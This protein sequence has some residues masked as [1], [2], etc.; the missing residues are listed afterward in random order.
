[1]ESKRFG[2]R[3]RELRAQKNVQL[4]KAAAGMDIDQSLLSK[5]ERGQRFANEGFVRKA[6]LYFGCDE[7]ELLALLWSDKFLSGI[8][9]ASLAGKAL[10][11]AEEEVKYQTRERVK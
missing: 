11:I 8:P 6:A 10:R 1:M 7:R 2:D 4:R 9:D 5:Y 3:L